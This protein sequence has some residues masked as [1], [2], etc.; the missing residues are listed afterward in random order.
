MYSVTVFNS[1]FDNQT[2][3][4]FD[5]D[6]WSKFEKFLYMLSERP[7]KGKKDAQ[8]ISP[9]VYEANTTRANKNVLAW[10]GWAAVDVDDHV[11]KGN[12]KDELLANFGKYQFICYSTAS[13]S[14]DLPKFRLVFPLAGDVDAPRIRHFWFALNSEL[15][16]LGDKQT[17]DL[18]RMYYIPANYIGSYNF[19][20]SN[21]S[22]SPVDPDALI[23]KWE[24]EEKRHSNNFLDRLPP[25]WAA[26]VIEHR[27]SKMNS[28]IRWT[29]YLDCPFVNKRL[30]QEYSSIAH[31]DGTGLYRMFYKIMTSIAINAVKREYPITSNEIAELLRQIDID[32]SNI[33]SN[34]PLEIEAD[35][36]IEY[37]YKNG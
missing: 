26:Q 17:K 2:D 37:A 23:A 7:L 34:R 29:N 14:R 35:R 9:A 15:G 22:G 19:I 33:Y 28:D 27:K 31:V 16:G 21:H 8:L 11:F 12:L 20:F 13:S 4:R 30:V 10:A 18:S 25:E 1:K 3:K 24:Y 6:E 5:F 32:N 36:A